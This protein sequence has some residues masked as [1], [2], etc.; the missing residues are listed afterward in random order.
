MA[1]SCGAGIGRSGAFLVAYL[2]RYCDM[3]VDGAIE[4]LCDHYHEGTWTELRASEALFLL[5][6]LESEGKLMKPEKKS[7]QTQAG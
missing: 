2:V 5:R 1:V 6:K 4:Y 7:P 3:T